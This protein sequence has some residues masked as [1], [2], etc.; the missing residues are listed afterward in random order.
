MATMNPAALTGSPY[1]VPPEPSRVP[2]I[3]MAVLMHAGLLLFLWAGISWQNTAP[4]SVEAEVWDLKT[5]EAAPEPVRAPEPVV[6]PKEIEKEVEAPPKAPDI[7]LERIKEQKQKLEKKLAEE[8]LLKKE[9]ADKK[10][11]EKADKL[12]KE[13]A[14]LAEKKLRD[15]LFEENMKQ[16]KGKAGSG[17]AAQSTAPRIDESYKAAIRTKIQ[18]A[19]SYNNADVAGN[20]EVVF[21]IEQMPTGEVMSVVKKK[22]SGIPAFDDA[23]ERGIRSASPLPKK[24]DGTVERSFLI[25][26]KP[27]ELD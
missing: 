16:L 14:E 24:K 7:A 17:T 3:M 15:K 8:K 13:K 9:L 27:K 18:H 20:P 4:V 19:V 22:S 23:V 5:Q 21:S 25:G 2:S 1:R 11:K 10:V 6:V 26:F 12:A